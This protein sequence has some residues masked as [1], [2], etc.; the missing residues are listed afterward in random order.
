VPEVPVTAPEP[1]SNVG[2]LVHAERWVEA[3]LALDPK[4]RPEEVEWLEAA[5]R[6]LR[7]VRLRHL[8]H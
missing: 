1:D 5:Q 3:V 7:N 6:V 8:G 4:L 2:R